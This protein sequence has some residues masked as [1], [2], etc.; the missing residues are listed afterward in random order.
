MLFIVGGKMPVGHTEWN[1]SSLTWQPASKLHTGSWEGHVLPDSGSAGSI[2]FVL[3]F[4]L[5]CLWWLS[6]FLQQESCFEFLPLRVSL[7]ASASRVNQWSGSKTGPR[8]TGFLGNVAA[9]ERSS[10]AHRRGSFWVCLQWHS[11]KGL[12][13]WKAGSAWLTCGRTLWAFF[14]N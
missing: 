8:K 12:L 5:W 6:T 9:T 13:F 11:F 1:L 4:P 14:C 7:D 3:S 10:T 2:S